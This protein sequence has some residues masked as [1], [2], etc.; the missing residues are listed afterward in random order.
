MRSTSIGIF[1]LLTTAP[2]TAM[3]QQSPAGPTARPQAA[4][5]PGDGSEAGDSDIVVR[6]ARLQGSVI[7]DIPP[8]QQLTPADIRSYGVSSVADLLSE[9]APQTRSGRGGGGAP[10]VLL[11]G[12]RIAGFNEIRDLPTEAILRVD[13]LPEE[14]ALKY[15]Y[16]ADQRVVNFVLRPRFRAVTTQLE[17]RLTTQGGIATPRGE[18]NLL[19]IARNGR[20]TLHADYLG[21]ES[22]T[23]ADRGI[24][25][26][27]NLFAEGGNVVGVNGG[28]I[29][30]LLSARAGSRVTVAG[31]PAI[32]A[33]RAPTLSDFSATAG[34]ANTTDQT[35]YR[36]LRPARNEFNAGIVYATS[37]LGNVSASLNGQVGTSNSRRLLGLAGA[38]FTVP[39]GNRFS[40]FSQDVIVDRALLDGFNPLGQT[41]K[42]FSG[43]FALTLN[44]TVG[45]WQWT[46]TGTYDR[47]DVETITDAGLDTTLYQA[48]LRA[49]DPTANPFGRLT[50]GDFTVLPGGRSISNRNRGNLDLVVNGSVL[51]LP[52][53]DISATVKAGGEL[54][55][56]SSSSVRGA[57]SQRAQLNRNIANGQVNVDIPITSRRT[58]FLAFAGDFSANFNIA[59]DHLSDF[60]TLRTLGYGLNWSPVEPIRVIASVTEQDEAP[61]IEQ[62]GDPTVTTPNVVVF[63]YVRGENALVSVV[64]GGNRGLVRDNRLVKK[65]ELN[66]KP[67]D[68]KD[69]TFVAN[70][71]D[72]RTNNPVAG[73]P[74]ATAAIEAA[75]PDRFTRDA[76]GRLVRIDQRAINFAQTS[77]SEIRLGFN[78]SQPLKSKIQRQIEAFRA[79]KGPNP[80]AG[81]TPPGGRA[82]GQGRPGDGPGGGRPGGGPGGGG[83]GGFGGGGRGGQGGGR[84]QFALYDTIHL[85]DR[86]QIGANGPTLDLLRGDTIGDRGGQARHEVEGQAGYTNNGLGARLSVNWTSGTRVIGGTAGNPDTLNFSPLGTAN[87]RLFADL[88]Q[89]LDLVRKHPWVRGMRV[90]VALDNVFNERQ[91]VTDQNGV[92][93]ISYQPGYLDPSG[94][95]IRFSIRKVFF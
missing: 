34:V 79:G 39:A 51:R 67:F 61:D 7:G 31:V 83:F 88:G 77:R 20:L 53:G 75:F 57:V 3:A 44:G 17:N 65:L 25:L 68:S 35:P 73:F 22:I 46:F 41:N 36:T 89:R 10:V 48:R 47:N 27:P 63:D 14:V 91:R 72:S 28:E 78:F 52:A 4:A 13:I 15:G 40:P 82:F 32:A 74:S 86:V 18:F 95:S 85:T 43:Y 16:R 62:L 42:I 19:R 87:L 21:Q 23:E 76:S 58:G 71:V 45:K 56:F 1:L 24:M 49:I 37:I 5:E 38:A 81:L 84:L 59:Y 69:L 11:N 29:D 70:Y 60:A 30:P 66:L 9:L 2:V 64:T 8:E 6:G 93:P 92:V 55:D 33:T 50:P 26:A 80:F 54:T 94:R 90:V 12:K